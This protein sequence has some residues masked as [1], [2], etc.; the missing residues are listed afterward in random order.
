MECFCLLR[1]RQTTFGSDK[2]LIRSCLGVIR[3]SDAT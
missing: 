1:N 3:S 2:G